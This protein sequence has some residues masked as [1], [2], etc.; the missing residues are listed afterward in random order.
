MERSMQRR[1]PMAQRVRVMAV[2][3]PAILK[4]KR[5]FACCGLVAFVGFGATGCAA[6]MH[7]TA[8]V[9]TSS[10]LAMVAP[11]VWVV[12][13]YHEPVFYSDNYYWT[14]RNG[15]WYRSHVYYGSFAPVS[16]VPRAVI[17]IHSPRRY[18]HYRAPRGVR[19]R[20]VGRSRVRQVHRPRGRAIVRPRHHH[21]GRVRVRARGR[22]R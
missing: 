5:F 22:V 3:S 13:R 10:Q 19:V 17:S 6:R 9:T 15:V 4:V 14:V 20:A 1:R 2:P 16:V 18:I 11:G 7:T 8:T 21:Q 12:T